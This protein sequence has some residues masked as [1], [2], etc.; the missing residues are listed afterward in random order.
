MDVEA[1][2]SGMTAQV[3]DTALPSSTDPLPI[4]LVSAS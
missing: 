1:A 4:P 3:F 2:H